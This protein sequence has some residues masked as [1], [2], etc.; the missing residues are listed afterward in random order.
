VSHQVKQHKA[1][2]LEALV[3]SSTVVS[4]GQPD[5][6]QL[7]MAEEQPSIASSKGRCGISGI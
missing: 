3:R 2:N 4:K 7:Q 1:H 5:W 6:H